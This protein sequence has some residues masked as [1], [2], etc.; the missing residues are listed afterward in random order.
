MF[1]FFSVV[2][3]Y[4]RAFVYFIGHDEKEHLDL[5]NNVANSF[6]FVH[7][8]MLG[9]QG[10]TRGNKGEQGVTRVTRGNKGEQGGTRGNMGNM[11]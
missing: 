8:W 5:P 2:L 6:E 4:Y 7:F 11:G 1:G 10:V 9:E 3:F